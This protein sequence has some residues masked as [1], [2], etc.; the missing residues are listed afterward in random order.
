MSAKIL[1]VDD[2]TEVCQAVSEHFVKFGFQMSM[3]HT[4]AEMCK[5]LARE[6]YAM[7]IL[8]VVLPDEDGISL[9]RRLRESGELRV[10]VLILSGRCDEVDRVIGLE[11]GADDYVTK[12][13]AIRE[14]VAR[15]R[16][17]LRR[18]NNS[19]AVAPN[20]GRTGRYI[21]FGSWRLDRIQ[22]CLTTTNGTVVQVTGTEYSL[23]EY[24]VQRP[25]RIISREQLMHHLSG[26]NPALLGRAIDLRISRL[27]HVL[28]QRDKFL[29]IK[30]V[31]NEGYVFACAIGRG[32]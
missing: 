4:G 21:D 12:P 17:V 2:D 7:V 20:E 24:F 1:I 22:R 18:S 13:F 16:A 29:Y 15:V 28:G 3:A 5:V 31:R 25:G 9:L 27:R 30:T 26:T 23:L 10:P 14:L 6:C 32:A 19:K 11:V 8:D